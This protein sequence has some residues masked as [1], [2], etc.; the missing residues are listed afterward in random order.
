MTETSLSECVR[1]WRATLDEYLRLRQLGRS[2][3]EALL[4]SGFYDAMVRPDA[5][6]AFDPRARAAR[7]D[8]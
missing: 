4:D 2:H 5:R 8:D 7:N 3:T 1:K 6:R